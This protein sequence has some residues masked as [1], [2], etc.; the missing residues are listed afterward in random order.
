[1]AGFSIIGCAI[2]S[3]FTGIPIDYF[4]RRKTIILGNVGVVVVSLCEM[5]PNFIWL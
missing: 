4:G 5:W 1:M 3:F 2:G